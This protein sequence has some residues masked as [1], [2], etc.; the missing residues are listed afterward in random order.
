MRL[1]IIQCGVVEGLE[2]EGGGLDVQMNRQGIDWRLHQRVLGRRRVEDVLVLCLKL[3]DEVWHGN[4]LLS[5]LLLFI[6]LIVL[7]VRCTVR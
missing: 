5:D 2:R 6:I 4:L 1:E 3:Q 7:I